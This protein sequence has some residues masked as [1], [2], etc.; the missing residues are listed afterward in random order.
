ME[1]ICYIFKTLNKDEGSTSPN[2][3]C[4]QKVTS[5]QLEVNNLPFSPY[6]TNILMSL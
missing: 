6:F 1:K 3:L 2:F 5:A 4:Q